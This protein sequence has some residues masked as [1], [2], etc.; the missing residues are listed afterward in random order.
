MSSESAVPCCDVAI[1]GGGMVGAS[2]ALAL[3][4]LPL[5]VVV[6]EPTEPDVGPQPSFDRRTTALANGSRRIFAGLGVWDEIALAATPIHRIHVSDRGRFGSA[7]IDAA[8][9][10]IPALGYVVEN[11]VIGRA[12]WRRLRLEPRVSLLAPAT[13]TGVTPAAAATRLTIEGPGGGALDARLVVAADGAGSLVRRAAGIGA[14]RWDYEQTAV[15]AQLSPERFHDH[16]AYERF[17]PTGPLALLPVADGRVGLVWT[18]APAQAARVQALAP[19]AFLTELQQCFGWRLGRF[20]S[21]GARHSY[22][23]ALTC[24]DATLAP[25]TVI[26]GNAAQAMHPIAGQGFNVGLRDAATLAEVLAETGSADPGGAA[27]LARYAAWRDRDR[28]ALIA[29]TD[30]L[31]RL[32]GSPFT[33]LRLARG[34]GLLALDLTP[35]AKSALSRLSLGFATRL[36]RLARGLPLVARDR[37]AEPR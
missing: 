20:T 7:L 1:V 19:A 28:R 22:P 13:V 35:P 21:V 6:V 34:L 32:F 15:I 26:I 27:G 33:P 4:A 36:P 23:L 5:A 10:G 16:V 3:A 31:V 30:G 24:A 18:L 2:L 12:L 9:Q 17:T 14:S 25:R 8:E 11:S 29:F 37:A